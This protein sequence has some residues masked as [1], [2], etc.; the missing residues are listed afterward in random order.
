MSRVT[1]PF[2]RR[3]VTVT[4]REDIGAYVVLT[5]ADPDGPHP[6]PGQF[7]MLAAVDRWGAGQDERPFLPRACSVLRADDGG[8]AFMLEDVGP[9]T[10]RLCGLEPGAGLWLVGPLG[11]GFTAPAD[12]RRAIL[13]GGG[14][15]VAPLAIWRDMLATSG[16]EVSTLLGFRD[17]GHAAGAMLLPGAEV[18]TDDG[19]SGHHGLVTDLLDAQLDADPHATVY[20]CGP[21][22]MLEAVRARCADRGVPAELALE[23]GMALLVVW[24]AWQYTTWATNEF[25]AD[26]IP[27]RLMLIVIMMACLLMAVAIPEAFGDRGLLFAGAYVFIQVGR[28]FVMTFL[29][30]DKG[31]VERNRAAHIFTWFCFSGVFWIAGA[32]VDGDARILLWIVA[33]M[34]DYGAPLISF[35]VPWLTAVK[36]DD[37]NVGGYH[38]AERFQLFTIIALGETI[39]LTGATTAGAGSAART[40]TLADRR[41]AAGWV[42]TPADAPVLLR[43]GACPAPRCTRRL[44]PSQGS[45]TVELPWRTSPASRIRSNP[46][47]TSC[48]PPRSG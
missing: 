19:S 8:L 18:A 34:M 42:A 33:L 24:W 23:S 47:S 20:S 17:A 5:A 41:S 7:Y 6:R 43:T 31:T 39:V 25:D 32:L 46:S 9:G 4:T 3:A 27:V 13:C 26:A 48:T 28:H 44:T 11:Q 10:R 37:W 45:P 14:V 16:H 40:T 1:A 38:F 12:G 36:S 2:G 29:A 35:R 15:G 22:G 30:A 21:P